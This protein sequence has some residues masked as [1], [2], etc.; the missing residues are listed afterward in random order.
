MKHFYCWLSKI[1]YS[2]ERFFNKR[3]KNSYQIF[4]M[5][6]KNNVRYQMITYI[7]IMIPFQVF[8]RDASKNKL[9]YILKLFKF[10]I[11][12]GTTPYNGHPLFQISITFIC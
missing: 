10:R 6:Y 4:L 5:F 1:Q 12:S 9:P 3:Y 7:K 2:D 8:Y 11:S